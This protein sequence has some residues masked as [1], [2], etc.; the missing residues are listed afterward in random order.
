MITILHGQD[1][2]ASRNYLN[3]LIKRAPEGV[4]RLGKNDLAVEKLSQI[5]SG[6]SLFGETKQIVT[7]NYLKQRLPSQ[8]D[9]VREMLS[10]FAGEVIVWEDG[11]RSKTVLSLFSEAKILEFKIPS[12]VFK[13]LDNVR[14]KNPK[15]N[16]ISFR[17]A[18]VG[19]SPEIIF[20]MLARRFVEILSPSREAADWQKARLRAQAKFFSKTEL[21][22]GIRELL[23]IDIAQ[24][25]SSTPF[26][27]GGKIEWFLSRL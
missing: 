2:V 1:E 21:V 20:S 12:T 10:N 17:Q 5:V 11:P 24:K 25:T 3:D 9:A 8:K 26:L 18:L 13:F 15:D 14:P 22:S 16:I 27:L 6:L 4:I 7:E 19:S 23:E